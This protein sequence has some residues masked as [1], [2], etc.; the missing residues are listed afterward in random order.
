MRWNI[1]SKPFRHSGKYRSRFSNQKSF[2][3]PKAVIGIQEA[4]V[5]ATVTDKKIIGLLRDVA[6]ARNQLLRAFG[7]A[8]PTGNFKKAVEKLLQHELIERTIPDKPNS[9]LQKYRLTEKGK[10]YLQ[11]PEGKF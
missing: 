1:L 9:R 5:E 7:Y 10:K 2:K 3:R 6:L 4:P 8:Q 11:S